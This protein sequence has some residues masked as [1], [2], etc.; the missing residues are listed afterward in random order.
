M[1]YLALPCPVLLYF[2]LPCLDLPCPALLYIALLCFSLP[3]PAFTWPCL[4]LPCPALLYLTLPCLAL[5]RPALLYLALPCFALVYLSLPCFTYPFLACPALP[6]RTL[7]TTLCW[8]EFK[9]VHSIWRSWGQH[10]PTNF[11]WENSSLGKRNRSEKTCKQSTLQQDQQ[12]SEKTSQQSTLL[13]IS[14]QPTVT[15][16][17]FFVVCHR[18]PL[19]LCWG[20]WESLTPPRLARFTTCHKSPQEAS[21]QGRIVGQWHAGEATATKVITVTLYITMAKSVQKWQLF[22]RGY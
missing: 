10:D 8:G 1:P 17:S 21:R 6:L 13:K 20:S 5:P 18:A 15:H 19:S 14:M 7:R 4:A 11:P 3:C 2:T 16:I 9:R 12:L 22:V